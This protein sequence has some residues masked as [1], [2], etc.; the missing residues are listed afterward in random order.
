[1][2][3]IMR[4]HAVWVFVRAHTEVLGSEDGV[5]VVCELTQT[6]HDRGQIAAS[7]HKI[8]DCRITCCVNLWKILLFH[9]SG[10]LL[11]GTLTG[12]PARG[13]D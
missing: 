7:G 5:D 9:G 6:G 12:T 11:E 3:D 10:K 4:I 13:S 8:F 2:V 1:M